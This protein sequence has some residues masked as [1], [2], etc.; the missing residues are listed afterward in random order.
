MKLTKRLAFV[1]LLVAATLPLHAGNPLDLVPADAVVVARVDVEGL[2]SSPLT[3]SAFEKTDSLT[4]DGE[5]EAFLEEAGL[6]LRRDVHEILFAM[7]PA[8]HEGG[9]GS[10]LLI[11][12]GAFSPQRLQ[13]ATARN[14]ELELRSW[15]GQTYFVGPSEDDERLAVAY[16][17]SSTTIIGSE[18]RV[19]AAL[20]AARGA[21]TGFMASSPLGLE[22]SRIDPAATAWLLVDVPRA[23]KLGGEA[24]AKLAN[25]VKL[26]QSLRYVSTIALWATDR[27]GEALEL[28]GLA[29]SRDRET[30]SLIEDSLRGM[31]AMWRLAVRDEKP[32]WLP[33]IRSFDIDSNRDSVWIRGS[34]PADLLPTGEELAAK[35]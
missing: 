20:T 22:M 1:A 8:K 17:D 15:S 13:S 33:V 9:K 31:T 30:L 24:S 29:V 18:E 3:R 7:T 28:A 16:F 35:R 6:D 23:Q 26:G 14:G 5:T 12:G 2:A 27:G 25:E 4:T 11:V 19:T 34:V 10:V 32:E 21:G